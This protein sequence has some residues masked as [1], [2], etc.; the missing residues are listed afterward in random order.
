MGLSGGQHI[1]FGVFCAQRNCL[2]R[3]PSFAADS[4]LRETQFS[5]R[6][7]N[8]R[9]PSGL[10]SL[11]QRRVR[12]TGPALS[13]CMLVESMRIFIAALRFSFIQVREEPLQQPFLLG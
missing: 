9:M 3:K 13:M 11:P 10:T 7:Y 4:P 1:R 8:A 12:Y 2:T 6:Q 5:L